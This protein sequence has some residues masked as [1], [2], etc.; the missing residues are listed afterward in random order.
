MTEPQEIKDNMSDAI[1]LL[2]PVAKS[3]NLWASAW[4]MRLKL[5]SL[6]NDPEKQAKEWEDFISSLHNMLAKV[7]EVYEY[8]VDAGVIPREA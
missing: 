3:G 6:N 8:L 5:A 7:K 2:E 4:L 1:K